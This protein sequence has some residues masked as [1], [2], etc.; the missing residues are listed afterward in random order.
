MSKTVPIGLKAEKGGQTVPRYDSATYG[1]LMAEFYDAWYPSI[2]AEPAVECLARLASAGPVLELGIGT[3]R[4][5]LPLVRR[6]LEVQGIDASPAMVSKLREK[7]DGDA[8]PVTIG[9]FADVEVD[10]RFSLVFIAFN[11]IF[12]LLTQEEQLRCFRNVAAKLSDGG[13]FVI[14]AFVPDLGRFDRGQRSSVEAFEDD[15]VRYEMSRHDPVR[16][17][18][19]SRHVVLSETGVRLFP[20]K[21]RY[22][23]PSELDLMARIAGLRLRERWGSWKREPFTATSSQHVS[24]YERLDS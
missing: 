12:A 9:D 16:Q 11:T 7:P 13:V 8:V 17:E 15:A 14:E 2:D 23:W 21:I 20:L 6:G 4:I 24:V 3:G 5:A 19:E 10:G 1:E 22:A 18:V